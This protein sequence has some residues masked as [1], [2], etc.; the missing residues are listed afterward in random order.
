MNTHH[1][2]II[3]QSLSTL[4]S[5]MFHKATLNWFNQNIGNWDVSKGISQNNTHKSCTLRDIPV[6]DILV[7]GGR[8]VKHI[9][10]KCRQ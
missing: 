10:L 1:C 5:W 4:Q 3:Q 2:C 8:T 9:I 7:E 6:T